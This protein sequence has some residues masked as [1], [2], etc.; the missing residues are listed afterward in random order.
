M[1]APRSQ[2][3]VILSI[4]EI[5]DGGTQEGTDGDVVDVM[6]IIF[7]AGNGDEKGR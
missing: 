5:G 7:E 6:P 3:R 4:R 1:T 2:S